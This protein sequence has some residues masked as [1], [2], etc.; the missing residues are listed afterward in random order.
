MTKRLEV[1]HV[2]KAHGLRGDLIFSFTTDRTDERTARGAV[3]F[4]DDEPFT[5]A[6]GQAHGKKWLMRLEGVTTKEQADD[7]RGRGVT[8]EPLD[9]ADTVF[10]HELIGNPLVDQHG[11]DRGK[12]VSV[13]DNPASDLLE[14]EGGGLVP[15]AFFTS[16]TDG[17]VL[18][19][20]PDGL[21]EIDP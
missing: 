2:A 13:I 12:I 20:V 7:L 21:F 9:D 1:G 3:L 14:L 8:A 6:H 4:L 19:D 10:V 5:V 17:I 18:V 16:I 15:L 11:V